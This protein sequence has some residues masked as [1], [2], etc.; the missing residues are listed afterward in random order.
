MEGLEIKNTFGSFQVN[1]ETRVTAFLRKGSVATSIR[2]SD[3]GNWIKTFASISANLLTEIVA[4]RCSAHASLLASTGGS[5]EIGTDSEIPV[6]VEYWVFGKATTVSSEGIQVFDGNGTSASNLLY[7]SS[8]IPIKPIQI[9]GSGNSSLPTGS[10]AAVPMNTR[11]SV[12][13]KSTTQIRGGVYET[14][15]DYTREDQAIQISG[16][17]AS[18]TDKIVEQYEATIRYGTGDIPPPE[19]TTEYSAGNNGATKYMIIDVSAL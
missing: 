6:T 13:R 3:D 16:S 19:G 17:S 8:W 12:V 7:D 4:F 18:V 15:L 10:F 2:Q 9:I 5:V 1:N 14:F 11:S